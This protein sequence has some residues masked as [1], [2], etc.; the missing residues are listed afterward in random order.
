MRSV[1]AYLK[2]IVMKEDGS[3][4][5]GHFTRLDYENVHAVLV[6]LQRTEAALQRCREQ[7]DTYGKLWFA[8]FSNPYDYN[9]DNA[10]LEEILKGKK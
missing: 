10:E 2:G 5:E 8:P 1:V 7:R 6:R 9:E 3:P 4:R